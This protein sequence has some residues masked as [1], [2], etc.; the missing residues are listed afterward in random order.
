MINKKRGFTLIELLV[1]VM[2]I[3]ILAAIAVPQYKRAVLKSRFSTVMPMA[4]SVADAQEVYYQGRQMYALDT[5]ELDV[6]PVT[7]EGASIAL[8][9]AEQEDHYAYVAA[10]STQVPGA[11]YI[12]YQKYSPRFAGTIQCEADATNEDALWLCEKGLS[13]TEIPGSGVNTTGGSYKTFLLAGDTGGATFIPPCPEG[14]TCDRDTGAVTGCNSGYYVNENSCAACPANSTCNSNT[15]AIIS[16][17]PGYY[18]EGSACV[19]QDTWNSNSFCEGYNGACQN[20]NFIA[21]R[22]QSGSGRVIGAGGCSNSTF[23]GT[24]TYC[25]GDSNYTCSK[26]TYTGLQTK[27]QGNGD[28]FACAASTFYGGSYCDAMKSSTCNDTKYVP[29][30]SGFLGCCNRGNCPIGTPKCRA[31]GTNPIWNATNQAYEQDGWWGDCCNPT[32]VGGEENCGTTP[33]CS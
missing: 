18:K 15:G 2:I 29:N 5:E 20:K 32:A 27:C 12:M 24:G 1:V 22:C 9:P 25:N 31:N 10:S 23:S 14:A 11:R 30:E 33:I 13:G 19:A 7:A 21:G 6:T 8:A 16:C 28:V 4:K 26:T 17:I 3:A